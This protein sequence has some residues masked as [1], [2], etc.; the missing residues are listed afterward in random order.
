MEE[1]QKKIKRVGS[2][3]LAIMLIIFGIVSFLHMFIKFDLLRYI[4]MIWPILFIVLGIEI[5][6]CNAKKNIQIKLD[7]LSIVLMFFII[8]FLCVLGVCNFCI[9]EVFYNN[10]LKEALLEKSSFYSYELSCKD[11]LY[12]SNLSDKKVKLK[13]EQVDLRY[14]ENDSS[15]KV[16]LSS[17][18]S[19][20]KIWNVIINNWQDNSI[21]INRDKNSNSK[22]II[23]NI[24]DYID[25]VEIKVLIDNK[26]K[27]KIDGNIEI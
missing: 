18:Y 5:L 8:G 16:I 27:I 2:I 3:T 9:N 13:V 15:S 17:N 24:P 11:E 12:I 7:F 22:I 1:N 19:E 4:L 20:S 10:E 21:L 25:D 14:D 6:V 23:T 26:D